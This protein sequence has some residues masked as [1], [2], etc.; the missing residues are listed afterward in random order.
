MTRSA[1]PASGRRPTI[2]KVQMRA[3]RAREKDWA[4]VMTT[5]SSTSPNSRHEIAGRDA[6]LNK[7]AEQIKAAAFDPEEVTHLRSGP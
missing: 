5:K 1:R 3:D 7:L 6:E 2:Q 4:G